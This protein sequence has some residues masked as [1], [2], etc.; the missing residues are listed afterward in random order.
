[1]GISPPIGYEDLPRVTQPLSEYRRCDVGFGDFR[2]EAEGGFIMAH[3]EN[4]QRTDE[5]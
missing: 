4:Q 5:S 3:G 1:M 2:K